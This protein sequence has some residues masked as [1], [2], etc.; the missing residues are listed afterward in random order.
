MMSW[1]TPNSTGCIKLHRGIQRK[2]KNLC[3]HTCMLE[4]VFSIS[5]TTSISRGRLTTA[6]WHADWQREET[7]DWLS[8]WLSYQ[9]GVSLWHCE[10]HIAPHTHTHSLAWL[11]RQPYTPTNCSNVQTKGMLP[12]RTWQACTS[13]C[14]RTHTDLRCARCADPANEDR[15]NINWATRPLLWQLAPLTQVESTIGLSCY[16]FTFSLFVTHTQTHT[17]ARQHV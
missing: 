10:T 5:M 13:S 7:G 8:G 6:T 9:Q 1:K 11:C 17:F 16:M 3:V 12:A 4:S 2:S 15:R 14:E